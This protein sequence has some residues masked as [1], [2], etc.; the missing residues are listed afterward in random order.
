[1]TPEYDAVLEELRGLRAD[2]RQLREAA[3][4]PALLT[5]E[6]LAALLRVT[7][8]T[9]RT[10]RHA[11]ESPQGIEIAGALR[12]RRADVDAWLAQKDGGA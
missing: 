4:T 6:D 9:L 1:M 3:P 12:W 8:R 10:W 5:I 11:G 2:L 7:T